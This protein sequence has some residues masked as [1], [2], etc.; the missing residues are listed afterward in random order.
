MGSK[1][2]K[3]Y[4]IDGKV[5]QKV[6]NFC[7]LEV[8]EKTGNNDDLTFYFCKQQTVVQTLNVTADCGQNV[9]YIAGFEFKN[10]QGG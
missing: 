7:G 9:G 6:A 1:V 8:Y 10:A 3:D 2:K 5:V 4:T